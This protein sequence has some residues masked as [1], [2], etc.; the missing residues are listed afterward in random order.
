MWS[1]ADRGKDLDRKAALASVQAK[2]VSWHPGCGDINCVRLV[3][4][5]LQ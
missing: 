2:D 4:G 5:G 1:K 3:R